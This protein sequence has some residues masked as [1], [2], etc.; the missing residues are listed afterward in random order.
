MDRYAERRNRLRKLLAEA[1]VDALLVTNFINVT[2]L[3]GFTGDDSYLLV[4]ESGEVLITDPRYTEQL[5]SECPALPLEVR[6]P[7]I[8]MPEG[9]ARAVAT[10]K[11]GR[12]G[13]E[14]DSITLSVRDSIQTGCPTLPLEATKGLV[15]R[16]RMIKDSFELDEI[17][18]AVW[19]A[20]RAFAIV[21]AML[22]PDDTERQVANQLEFQMRCDGAKGCSFTPIIGVGPR[23]A[24]PHGRPADSK[25]GDAG[26]VLID[27]GAS[28]GLYMS[29]LTRVLITGNYPPMLE[30]I[31]KIVLEAQ[32]AAIA[33]IRPGLPCHEIDKAAR[34]VI[35]AAGYG[36]K[37][38]HGLGHGV[39]LEIH[40]NPRFGV[41][42]NTVLQPGMVMTVE[43]GI[44]LPGV[45]GVRIEDD[46]VVT[47]QGCEVLTSVGKQWEEI[48]A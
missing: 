44:Y 17:R 24:L 8:K 28:S 34:D 9:I 2:Y 47:E 32:L 20:E 13:I 26:F 22:R 41:G 15:E 11:P 36:D 1:K 43:P 18:R 30:T 10:L 27:W 5:E 23:A 4:G 39:G 19:Q 48:R 42:D 46:I 21:R 12:L 29:D 33:A 6:T 31:Y 16:L 35:T 45:L 3:T 37:F 38:G 40:E 14:S 7:G 25:I